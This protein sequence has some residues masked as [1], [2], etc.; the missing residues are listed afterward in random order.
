VWGAL[1]R[2]TACSRNVVGRLLAKLYGVAS[3]MV[4][5]VRGRGRPRHTDII[6]FF[7]L[8]SFRISATMLSI[9]SLMRL[10]GRLK[11]FDK[12]ENATRSPWFVV[13]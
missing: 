7:G 2:L 8:S 5:G 11:L 13:A 4:S 1:A 3:G 10:S 12:M 9:V 6:H